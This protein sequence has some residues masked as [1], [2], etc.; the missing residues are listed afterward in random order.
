MNSKV[1]FIFTVGTSL[2][3]LGICSVEFVHRMNEHERQNQ[4]LQHLEREIN[5]VSQEITALEAAT[6]A[7]S[8]TTR[9]AK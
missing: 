9:L 5:Q 4:E 7:H 3:T 2:V 6:Q 1:F 8:A